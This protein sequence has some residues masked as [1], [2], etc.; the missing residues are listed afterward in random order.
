MC[1]ILSLTKAGLAFSL[2]MSKPVI[3]LNNPVNIGQQLPQMMENT[4]SV[5]SDWTL[6]NASIHLKVIKTYI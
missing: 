4:W 6:S 1:F 2:F 5:N 3:I